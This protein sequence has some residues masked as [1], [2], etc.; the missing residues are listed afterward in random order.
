MHYFDSQNVIGE[1]ANEYTRYLSNQATKKKKTVEMPLSTHSL[2]IS[3]QN[4]I[5]NMLIRKTQR[6]S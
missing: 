5:S 2:Y 6:D 4:I 3:R 1:I